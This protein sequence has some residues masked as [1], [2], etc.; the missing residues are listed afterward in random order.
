[1]TSPRKGTET[2][3]ETPRPPQGGAE[4]EMT[5]PRK[6]TETRTTAGVSSPSRSVIV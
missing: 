5:S 4:F 1:M 3:A 6:G 2:V